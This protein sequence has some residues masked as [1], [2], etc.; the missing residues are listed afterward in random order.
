MQLIAAYTKGDLLFGLQERMRDAIPPMTSRMSIQAAKGIQRRHEALEP[1]LSR[2]GGE[3]TAAFHRV[4]EIARANPPSTLVAGHAC[5]RSRSLFDPRS[6]AVCVA[7]NEGC[8][9]GTVAKTSPGTDS[10]AA[11]LA[12]AATAVMVALVGVLFCDARATHTGYLPHASPFDVML[13]HAATPFQYRFLVPKAVFVFVT[14]FPSF[15]PQTRLFLA[16]AE[17]LFFVGAFACSYRLC[18]TVAPQVSAERT[19]LALLAVPFAYLVLP[20]FRPFYYACDTPAVF[21][22]VAC[23]LALVQER[24]WLFVALFLVAM[25]NRETTV[26]VL[27]AWALACA[28][29]RALRRDALPLSVCLV[30]F[31]VIKAGLRFLYADNPGSGL[32]QMRHDI[33]AHA[34]HL[35]TNLDDLVS[36]PRSVWFAALVLS[37]LALAVALKRTVA[38]PLLRA[39]I[40]VVPCAV[41][42]LLIVG[43]LDEFRMFADVMMLVFLG[44]AAAGSSRRGLGDDPGLADA[45]GPGVAE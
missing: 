30:G 11:P 42:L 39:C 7:M 23:M 28:R 18:R 1:K 5:S 29:G 6:N 31:V 16:V 19:V 41:L 25:L 32:V 2:W 3:G 9:L 14:L 38:H 26:V 8:T 43:N 15:V 27:V 10:A 17:W 4:T 44:L 21:F 13:G 37:P 36:F 34:L 35:T 12:K 33:G 22:A 24:R 45:G 40:D 20:P